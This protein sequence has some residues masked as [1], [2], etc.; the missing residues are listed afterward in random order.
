M[1]VA[2]ELL[3]IALFPGKTALKSVFSDPLP[4]TAFDAALPLP[5]EFTPQVRLLPNPGVCDEASGRKEEVQPLV[6]LH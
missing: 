6:D 4:D 5:V 2:I 1:I 3:Q